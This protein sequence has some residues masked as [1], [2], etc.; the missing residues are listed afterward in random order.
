MHDEERRLYA[1]SEEVIELT[2][3]E[4]RLLNYLIKNKGKVLNINNI[5]CY[6]YGENNYYTELSIRN[7]IWRLRNKIQDVEIANIFGYGY[8]IF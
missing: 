1:T 5:A 7:L 2:K 8:V 6:V 3:L 4:N